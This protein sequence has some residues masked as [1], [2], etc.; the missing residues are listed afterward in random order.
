MTEMDRLL[1]AAGMTRAQLTRALGLHRNTVAGWHGSPPQ[2]A[3]AYLQLRAS[4]RTASVAIADVL[5]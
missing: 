1:D 3:V 5:R 2:Y 4:I